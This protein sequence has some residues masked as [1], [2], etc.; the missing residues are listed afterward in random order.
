MSLVGSKKKFKP[1]VKTLKDTHTR[2]STRVEGETS[3]KKSSSPTPDRDEYGYRRGSDVSVVLDELLKG[4]TDKHDVA[5][6]ISARFQ[7]RTTRG[8]KQK[9][10]ST[11]MNQI[12]N[13]MVKRGFRVQSSWKLLPPA[14]GVVLP[15]PARTRKA[16][17]NA[18]E[19]TTP[20]S[21]DTTKHHSGSTPQKPTQRRIKPKPRSIRK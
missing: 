16:T 4:G 3:K 5:R 9:P 7:G 10:I 1:R 2:T 20:T 19:A 8:G 12:Q 18:A 15:R 11:V 14:N 6:R 13:E 17:Q 21:A